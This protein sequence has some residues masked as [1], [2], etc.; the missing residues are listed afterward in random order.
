MGIFNFF[1]RKKDDAEQSENVGASNSQDF[2]GVCDV[3]LD[4]Q[5]TPDRINTLGK[6][7]IFV[8]GSN[9]AGRHDGDA[10]RIALN[11]FG[12]VYGQGEGL[13]GNSYAIPTMQGGVETIEPYVDRFIEFAQREKALT[14]YVT[15]IGCGIAGFNVANIAP[16]FAKA[17]GIPNIRLPKDFV[18]II[19][20]N[21]QNNKIDNI[22]GDLFVHVHGVT[23]TF[24]DL[25]IS[26][27]NEKGFQNLDEVMSFLA[28]YFERFR[29]TGD[30]VA[31]IAVRVF[32]DIIRDDT[33]FANGQLN[34]TVLKERLLGFEP[35]SCK[36]NHA[37]E[38][39]CREKL[40]NVVAYLNLFRRYRNANELLRD[41]DHTGITRFS[42]CGLN[43][44]MSP[45]EAGN[46]YPRFYFTRF[47]NWNWKE[48][49]N[50]DGTLDSKKLE[51]L[52]FNKHERSLRKYGL[53]AVLAHDYNIYAC[54]GAFTP[55][56]LGTGP[57]YI[58]LGEGNY[59]ISCGEGAGPNHIPNYLG[60]MVVT[61]ILE[62][63]SHYEFISGYFIPKHDITLPIL[64]GWQAPWI[65]EFDNLKDKRNFI[66][67]LRRWSRG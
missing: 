20:Q 56:E 41:I 29:R 14:F 61:E 57:V 30:E 10:A 60:Y 28:Q 67:S 5:Y 52:M 24:A 17:I 32:W 50:S 25:V 8:F 34:V 63:D 11:R 18:D 16:L 65:K 49:L 62:N 22:R 44:F 6:K 35:H 64:G 48:L 7:D 23:R 58:D 9:L 43:Y 37:Y 33:L 45:I 39:H 4:S 47:L 42:H 19:S 51:E 53:E 55:K 3:P 40:F 26:Q 54:W 27:N 21:S 12:A 46:G 2:P 66:D 1:N 38:F 31:F 15:K 59:A 36:I 13:Q